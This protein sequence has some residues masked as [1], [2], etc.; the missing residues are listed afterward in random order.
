MR[1][2]FIETLKEVWIQ[3]DIYT[4]LHVSIFYVLQVVMNFT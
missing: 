1:P 2:M 3:Y 4:T